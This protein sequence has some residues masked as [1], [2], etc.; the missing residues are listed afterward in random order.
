[1]K[2]TAKMNSNRKP[3]K[4]PAALQFRPTRRA[5]TSLHYQIFLVIR[6]RILS[7]TYRSGE[8]LPSEQELS[9]QFHVSR[10]TMRTAMANLQANGLVE[11]RQGVG[12]FVSA[13]DATPQLHTPVSDL[14]AHIA[15]VNRHTQVKLFEM[16]FVTAPFHV[17]SLFNCD[18][19]Q[20]YQRAVR[21]RS[22]WD[23]PV[24]HVITYIPESIARQFT[25]KEMGSVSLN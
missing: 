24:F 3:A 1:M 10:I 21:V 8:S 13:R 14:L 11:R 12:T 25:R 15:D 2:P 4:A 9:E 22:T 18:A 17:Q 5:G 6:D 7:G 16:D 20:L 23:L 19:E